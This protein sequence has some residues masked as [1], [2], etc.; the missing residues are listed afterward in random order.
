[1]GVPAPRPDLHLFQLCPNS[2]GNARSR[3]LATT[4]SFDVGL[5]GAVPWLYPGESGI[6]LGHS[7][8]LRTHPPRVLLFIRL[9]ATSIPVALLATPATPPSGEFGAD[10]RS[11]L[12][13]DL[14]Y[15]I[16]RRLTTTRLSQRRSTQSGRSGA[17]HGHF[18]PPENG[19][20]I[21]NRLIKLTGALDSECS[22]ERRWAK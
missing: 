6:R 3:L 19:R 12:V 17:R 14:R 22:H 21:Y 2:F 4:H 18:G 8:D 20:D 1:M 11:V 16:N 5:P 13:R 10:W 7:G 15:I 9:A